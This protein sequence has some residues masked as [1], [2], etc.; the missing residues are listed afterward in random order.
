MNSGKKKKTTAPCGWWSLSW[1]AQDGRGLLLPAPSAPLP[2]DP[3]ASQLLGR[4]SPFSVGTT[5]RGRCQMKC[6]DRCERLAGSARSSAS[7]L[8]SVLLLDAYC[9]PKMRAPHPS[10]A[11][12]LGLFLPWGA[13]WPAPGLNGDPLST[14]DYKGT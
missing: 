5:T 13:R 14:C 11:P 2:G 8:K 10:C 9:V 12:F 1:I 6:C 3:R 4:P 7:V